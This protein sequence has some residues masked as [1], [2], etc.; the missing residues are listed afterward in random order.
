MQLELALH[1]DPLVLVVNF[2]FNCTAIATMV[3]QLPNNQV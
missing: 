2:V 3:G 1:V